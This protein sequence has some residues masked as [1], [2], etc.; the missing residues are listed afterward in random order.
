MVNRGREV[1]LLPGNGE[2]RIAGKKNRKEKALC[3]D[4]GPQGLG[5]DRSRKRGVG[6]SDE[7]GKVKNAG[8]S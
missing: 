7:E 6:K 4:R 8:K 3:V 1:T 5:L 2:H